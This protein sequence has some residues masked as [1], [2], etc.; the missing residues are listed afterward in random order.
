MRK[1][2]L[3]EELAARDAQI[4]DLYKQLAAALNANANANG[5]DGSDDS[6]DPEDTAD[7]QPTARRGTNERSAKIPDPPIFYNEKD[8]DTEE[9]EQWYRDIENKLEVNDD[10]FRNDRARQ[11]YVESRL[12]GKAKRELAPYLRNTHPTPINTSLKLLVHLWKQY[13]DPTTE[14][15]ALDEYD[16]LKLRPGDDFLAFKNDFVR[17]AGETGKPRSTWKHEFNRKLY[18][19]FQ[20]SMVPSFAS[21]TVTFDQFVVEAQQI[22]II[23]KRASE[24][25]AA[26]RQTAERQATNRQRPNNA[27]RGSRGGVRASIF[28]PR[29]QGATAAKP[30]SADEVKRLYEEGRCFICREKGHLA[31]DCLQKERSRLHGSD[32]DRDARVAR[33][34]K[35]WAAKPPEDLCKDDDSTTV[36]EDSASE[37]EN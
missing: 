8:R 3:L 2:E 12:G 23:N 34:Q 28:L 29:K 37:Q 10:H 17:L 5:D 16:N 22:A 30:L 18:D 19:S 27:A 25:H 1:A 13:Y 36:A 14:Q 21:P 7:T 33:L 9:F 6:D 35:R 15:K 4:V 24:R 20:R 32:P 11:A 31:N 26:E